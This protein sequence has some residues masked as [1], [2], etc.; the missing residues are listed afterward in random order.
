ML[1]HHLA[2]PYMSLVYFSAVWLMYVS[3]HSAIGSTSQV[4]FYVSL[5][6]QTS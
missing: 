2:L 3:P 6:R 1:V 4:F 5:V